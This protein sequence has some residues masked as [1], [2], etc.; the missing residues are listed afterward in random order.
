[1]TLPG[2]GGTVPPPPDCLLGNGFLWRA[3]GLPVEREEQAPV[4]TA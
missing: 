3:H 1:M 2:G 4:A